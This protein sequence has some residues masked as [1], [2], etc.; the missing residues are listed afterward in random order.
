VTGW[1]LQLP[2]QLP[3]YATPRSGFAHTSVNGLTIPSAGMLV[4]ALLKSTEDASASAIYKRMLGPKAAGLLD[5]IMGPLTTAGEND[6]V[7]R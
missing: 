1:G 3:R 6:V 7:E 2:T 5:S 4:D